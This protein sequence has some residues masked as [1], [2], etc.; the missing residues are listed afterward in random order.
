M[1]HC[2]NCV[3]KDFGFSSVSLYE[4]YLLCRNS[5]GWQRAVEDADD[6]WDVHRMSMFWNEEGP[7]SWLKAF[8]IEQKN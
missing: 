4:V 7:H 2:N 5:Y 8:S 1:Y 6:F 3:V